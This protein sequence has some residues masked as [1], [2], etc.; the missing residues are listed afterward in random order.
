MTGFVD[1]HIH[2]AF[3][4]DVTVAERPELDRLSAELARVGYAGFLPTLVPLPVDELRR[5]VDRLAAWISEVDDAIAR[6]LGVHFE[7]PF[8]SPDRA[9]AL[10]PDCFLDGRSVHVSSFL[11]LVD[12][13]PGRHMVTIAPEIAGGVELIAELR[14]RRVL[15]SIGH[16]D[17]DVATL[18]RAVE[19]GARHMTHFCNAMRPLHHREPG[20]IG[21]GLTCDDVTVDLIADLHHVH[22][23]TIELVLRARGDDRVALI[24]D[25]IPAAGLPDGDHACWGETLTVKDGAVR[26]R[27]GDL[28][29]SVA[30]LARCRDNVVGVGLLSHDR[31]TAAAS[32]VPLRILDDATGGGRPT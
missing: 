17:A 11:E 18:E 2:G 22:P 9:G 27:N 20:P 16:T 6:P 25:A 14:R 31:A 4:V 1:L 10:H 7:G 5:C 12:A 13:L 24:S 23:R 21:F 32:E 8:V 3:G 19:A 29:G 30:L 26:N 15:V 28:A